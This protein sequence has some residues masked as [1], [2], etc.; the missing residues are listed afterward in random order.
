[1]QIRALGACVLLAACQPTVPQTHPE[2]EQ[3][4]AS[5]AATTVT[6]LDK[7]H[8]Q[9][10]LQRFEQQMQAPLVSKDGSLVALSNRFVR[11]DTPPAKARDL[12]RNHVL[13]IVDVTKDRTTSR[14][15]Y[16]LSPDDST[17]V[18]AAL[19][20][21]QALLA[22]H[23][24]EPLKALTIVAD[25]QWPART[26]G[27]GTTMPQMA[28]GAGL[29]VQFHEPEL[30][31]RGPKGQQILT[32]KLAS[33]STPPGGSHGCLVHTDLAQA[34]ASRRHGVLAVEV[35]F[36]A[37]PHHCDFAPALHVVRFGGSKR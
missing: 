18:S 5:R 32:A 6:N 16:P 37:S 19:A 31:V 24:W 22:K 4:P 2:P 34:W 17:A 27:L 23:E 10:A 9:A 14:V 21:A 3:P 35:A 33:W 15:A 36:S 13:A 28:G 8:P 29:T 26:H 25:E 20:K 7:A 11:T 12:K 30:L 1:M